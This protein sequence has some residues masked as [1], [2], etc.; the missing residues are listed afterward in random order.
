MRSYTYHSGEN[1]GPGEVVDLT[2]PVRR[3]AEGLSYAERF[4]STFGDFDGI[5]MRMRFTGLRSRR[6]ISLTKSRGYHE[7]RI[8]DTDQVILEVRATP[9]QVRNNIVEVIHNLLAPLYEKFDF[10]QLSTQ[11]VSE[12]IEDMQKQGG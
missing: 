8:S 7:N 10:Y 6:L 2:Y 11:V 4:G 9:Q 3:V 5:A 1:V 12:E